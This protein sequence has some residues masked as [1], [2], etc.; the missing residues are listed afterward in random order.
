MNIRPII[1]S[2][3]M[4]R[5][6]LEGRKTQTRRVVKDFDIVRI[7]DRAEFVGRSPYPLAQTD[8]G[9]VAYVEL[10]DGRFVGIPCPYGQPGDL[11]WMRETWFSDPHEESRWNDA[12]AIHYRATEPDWWRVRSHGGWNPS[13]HMPRWASRITL[14][15]TDVRVERVQEITTED[16]WAEGVQIPVTVEG[17]PL[18]R[19]SSNAAGKIPASYLP[20]GR[21]FRGQ[22][23]LT[24]DELALSHFADL[25]DSINATRG[26]GWD[27]NPW[28]W[29]IEFEVIR[30]NID[31]YLK[32]AA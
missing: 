29:V 13:I 14:L 21:C 23:P 18:I 15:L 10:A 1:F 24:E 31:D 26:Y 19:L 12:D 8:L 17:R 9:G 27:E 6:L 11:L 25:W 4:V 20:K 2:G 28:V 22:P 16:V 32:E 5:A 7:S 30:M 3:A